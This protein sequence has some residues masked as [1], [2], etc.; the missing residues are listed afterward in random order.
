MRLGKACNTNGGDV[1]LS[2]AGYET[3]AVPIRP[4]PDPGTR[5]IARALTERS[6]Y[7]ITP[8]ENA[9]SGTLAYLRRHLAASPGRRAV[10][11]LVTD[12]L[13]SCG[14]VAPIAT[15]LENAARAGVNTYIVGLLERD[16]GP[17][18]MS[19]R[20]LDAFAVAG[21]TRAP[22]LVASDAGF[23]DRFLTTL[24]EIRG[25]A[26][27]CE[28]TIPP[29]TMGAIDYGRVNLRL[30]RGDKFED[31]LNTRGPGQCD[32]GGWYYDVDPAM[33]APTRVIVCPSTCQSFQG[34]ANA[35]VELRFG[36]QARY[37]E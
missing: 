37:V 29:A 7:G 10:M 17:E 9:V 23:Q 3:V 6:P 30:T 35:Q 2:P 34:D 18:D 16:A 4:L 27:P 25:R 15:L 22:L 5:L 8:I 1:C 36:C 12:A 32:K 20:N 11:V 28:F 21:G 26:L 13:P 24:N 33:K 14:A 19:R 31:I